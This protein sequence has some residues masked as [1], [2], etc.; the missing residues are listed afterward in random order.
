LR[1]AVERLVQ[2]YD[3]WNKPDEAARWRKEL[4]AVT[5]PRTKK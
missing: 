1:A 2:L 4:A 3:G 5:G